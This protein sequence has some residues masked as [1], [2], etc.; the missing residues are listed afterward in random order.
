MEIK[1]GNYAKLVNTL[2]ITYYCFCCFEYVFPWQPVDHNTYGPLEISKIPL[3]MQTLLM[4]KISGGK[5]VAANY[6]SLKLYLA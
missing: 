1:C 5:N 3:Y 6:H 4:F 2:Q